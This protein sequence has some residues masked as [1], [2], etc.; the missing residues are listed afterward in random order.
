MNTEKVIFGFFVL[1]AAT[2]NFEFFIGDL[3]DPQLHNVYELFAAVVVNLI[4]MV[5]KFG[6]RT[7]IGAVQLACTSL[8]ASLQLIAASAVGLRH[9]RRDGRPHPGDDGERHL[10]LRRS[11]VRQRRLGRPPWS[12]PCPSSVAEPGVAVGNPLLVLWYGSSP[13]R[14][15]TG[16]RTAWSARCPSHPAS[17]PRRDPAGPAPDADPVDR[18]DRD[19]RGERAGPDPGAR[20]DAQGRPTRLGIFEAF[21]FMSFT[22]TTIGLGEIPYTFTPAQRM[23]V[24]FAIFLS[25]IGWA[26]AVG[27]LLALMQDRAFRRALA[28]RLFARKVA[29]LGEPFLLLVGY[30][31]ATKGL[32]AHSTTW[33]RRFVV[34]DRDENRVTGV[35]LDS[36][37]ADTPAMLGDARDTGSLALAGLGHRHCEGVV[38]LTGNDETNLDVAMRRRCCARP[39]GDR[40]DE[41][42]R[43]RRA[44]AAFG[45]PDVV[46]PLDRF[47][48]HLRILLRSP[49]SYRLM[50]WLTSAP[51]SPLR[52]AVMLSRADG[53]WSAGTDA[54]AASSPPTC[55][56]RAWR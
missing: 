36:Y 30:G 18:A 21:Y 39:T 41:L 3:G 34:I 45:E 14:T 25:V 19:L 24:T 2:L 49:S 28:R 32:P 11:A 12:R 22:A 16:G 35:D 17:S 44:H 7:Q 52:R 26:Y 29:H 37:R 43:D 33:G 51:G 38:T 15:R 40:P 10:P 13:S 8:V 42:P 31:N 23:W 53:G 50:V 46:N 54:S 6:D 4:A 5:L 48:D 1:L 9:E 56:R 55:A 47:G 27:S 20:E